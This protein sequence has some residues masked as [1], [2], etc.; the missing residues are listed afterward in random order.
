MFEIGLGTFEWDAYING[1]LRQVTD[2]N[3]LTYGPQCEELEAR[4]AEMHGAKYGIVTASGTDA[5]IAALTTIKIVRGL[6]PESRVAVP[7][8][9][10]VASLN[11]VLWAGLTPHLVDIG[12]DY[13]MDWDKLDVSAVSIAMPVHLFGKQA[14]HVPG[15]YYIVEDS[16]EAVFLPLR[17][18]IACHSFYAA[19]HFV[20][21]VGGIMV[22]NDSGLAEIARSI[23]NHGRDVAYTH[24]DSPRS[25]SVRLARF[26]FN[27][28]GL[29]SRM[30]E[31]QAAIVLGQLDNPNHKEVVHRRAEIA[32]RFW[33][34]VDRDRFHVPYPTSDHAHMMFPIMLKEHN[35]GERDR[36][37][38]MFEKAGVE[39][40]DAMPLLSQPAYGGMFNADDYPMAKHA[41]YNAFA[42]P[43][44]QALTA[45]QVSH[46]CSLLEKM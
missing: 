45:K 15:G 20:G 46:I 27:Y 16:C 26:R 31:L 13:C 30:T 14:R 12:S 5:L 38:A 39:T 8:L 11:A 35:P 34:H 40:R 6:N 4:W 10:F 32:I 9:T 2:A 41:T 37:C 42:I 25:E 18:D 43:C 1:R 17:G 33:Y 28:V 22:T 23:V 36:I 44:H 21:G 3:R 24:V 7:A 29:S 19:H